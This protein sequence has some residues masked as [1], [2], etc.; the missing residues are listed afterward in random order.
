MA[1]VKN[2]FQAPVLV[3]VA[4]RSAKHVV[5]QL[6][7]V[8]RGAAERLHELQCLFEEAVVA[9]GGVHDNRR[10]EAG[11]HPFMDA[12][13]IGVGGCHGRPLM[14]RWALS[15]YLWSPFVCGS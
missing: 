13:L 10:R 12:A 7:R 14:V 1:S 9:L 4:V 8:T 5:N 3:D 15:H 11:Q 2:H 6:M